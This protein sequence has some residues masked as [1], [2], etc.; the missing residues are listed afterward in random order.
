MDGSNRVPGLV[1]VLTLADSRENLEVWRRHYY[2]DQPRFAIRINVPNAL[3]YPSHLQ[4]GT[5]ILDGELH[6]PVVPTWGLEHWS[7]KNLFIASLVE[8]FR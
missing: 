4:P 1:L 8:C 7:G 6:D 3:Y 2:E 5:V